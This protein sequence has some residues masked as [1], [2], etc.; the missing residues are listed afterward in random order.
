MVIKAAQQKRSINGVSHCVFLNK[1]VVN[2]SNQG[3]PEEPNTGSSPGSPATNVL[4]NQNI[5]S[6]VVIIREIVTNTLL[7]VR[8]VQGKLKTNLNN[9][10]P[11]SLFI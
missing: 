1:L 6:K 11:N 5:P 4:I 8:E 9:L 3:N 7:V 10:F 2:S